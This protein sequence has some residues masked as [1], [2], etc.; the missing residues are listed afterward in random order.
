VGFCDRSR[1]HFGVMLDVFGEIW[2]DFS[3]ETSGKHFFWRGEF[4]WI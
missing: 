1:Q 2:I 4:E 3:S